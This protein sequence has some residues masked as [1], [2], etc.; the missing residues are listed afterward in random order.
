MVF[1][2]TRLDPPETH[3]RP[4]RGRRTTLTPQQLG[5]TSRSKVVPRLMTSGNAVRVL[6]IVYA[7]EIR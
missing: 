4:C 7:P 2:W 5:H 6:K 3:P 1:Q